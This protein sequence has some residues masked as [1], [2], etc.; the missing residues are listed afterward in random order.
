MHNQVFVSV[1]IR[2]YKRPDALK[3]LII[4]LRAQR[5]PRFEIVIFEQ[6]DDA[7][8]V[9]ELRALDDP[10][11]CLVLSLPLDPPAARN[12][13]IRHAQGEVILL[14]D[15][16]DLPIGEDW[17]ERHAQN[18][19]DES[20]MGVVG[21]WAK[22][23][24]QIISPRFPRIVRMFALRFTIW[25]DTTGFAHNSLRKEDIGI[26]LGSNA[27]FRRS[28]LQRIGGWDEGIHMGEEQSFAIKFARHR[29]AGEKLVFDPT[30]VMWRRTDVP[31]G[32]ERRAGDDW[33]MRDLES[34]LF[35]YRHVVAHYFRL[36]YRLLFPLFWLRAIEQSLIWI[37]DPD[38]SR[39]SFKERLSASVQLFVRFPSALRS[40][41]FLASRVRRVPEWD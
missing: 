41:R 38:N 6:S 21:R 8:L 40:K 32:L 34:R 2:S 5:Y 1:V 18:Y 20:C 11:I 12:E 37:W 7:A 29:L 22:D 23:P 14:M 4:R 28:L 19:N 31:G 16:D 26:F 25:K 24:G 9:R 15:D 33:H 17:I 10:R 3:E 27:S 36:R 39:R 30:A 13:A 35:Y